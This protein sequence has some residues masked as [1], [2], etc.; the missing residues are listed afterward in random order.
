MRE[1]LFRRM[2]PTTQDSLIFGP[3]WEEDFTQSGVF[4]QW[5]VAEGVTV[6]MVELADGT[7]EQVMPEHLKF[8]N[9]HGLDCIKD[10]STFDAIKDAFE[11]LLTLLERN[12]NTM[13][14]TDN[15]VAYDN[16]FNIRVMVNKLH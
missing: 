3:K 4:H 14:S 1:V 8:I 13:P 2:L 16:A 5:A 11:R 6:A 7:V 15:I 10:L 12:K 9:P